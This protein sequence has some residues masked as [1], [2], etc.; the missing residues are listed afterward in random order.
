MESMEKKDLENGSDKILFT[1]K[2]ARIGYNKL[3]SDKGGI[4]IMRN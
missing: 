4:K 3:V 2:G 1:D